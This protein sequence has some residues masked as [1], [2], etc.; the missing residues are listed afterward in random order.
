MTQS[1]DVLVFAPVALDPAT[2]VQLLPGSEFVV[3]FTGGPV[4]PRVGVGYHVSDTSVA[5]VADDG[6]TVP[7]GQCPRDA[8]PS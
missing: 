5:V 4:H 7:P 8:R 3:R 2:V 6:F 1:F